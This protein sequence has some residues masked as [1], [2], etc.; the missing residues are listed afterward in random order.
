MNAWIDQATLVLSDFRAKVDRTDLRGLAGFASFPN[1][2][3]QWSSY[4]VAKMLRDSGQDGWLGVSGTGG[5]R[6]TREETHFWLQRDGC[7]LDP[8]ADQFADRFSIPFVRIGSHPMAKIY[9]YIQVV[10]VDDIRERP[11]IWKAYERIVSA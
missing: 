7:T 10:S 1:G 6:D 11:A 4:V 9:G 3:C 2:S 5:P 8:T